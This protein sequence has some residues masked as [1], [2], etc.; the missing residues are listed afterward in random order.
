MPMEELLAMYGYGNGS[1]QPLM[2]TSDPAASNSANCSVGSSSSSSDGDDETASA[3][4]AGDDEQLRNGGGGIM[5]ISGDTS[6]HTSRLLRCEQ[7]RRFVV[8]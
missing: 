7:H 4:A 6:M 5:G 3:A 2:P 8:K 1:Q